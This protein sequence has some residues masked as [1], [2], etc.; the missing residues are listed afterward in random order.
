MYSFKE[1]SATTLN[2]TY[3]HDSEDELPLIPH[4]LAQDF[5]TMW[6]KKDANIPHTIESLTDTFC[7]FD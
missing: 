5:G 4:S 1:D 6:Q 7:M 3:V 2:K